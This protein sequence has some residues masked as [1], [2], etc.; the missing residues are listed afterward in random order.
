[1]DENETNDRQDPAEVKSTETEV[2]TE[3]DPQGAVAANLA[4]NPNPSP[5][6]PTES[7]PVDS[8]LQESPGPDSAQQEATP[9]EPQQSNSDEG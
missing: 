5:A 3:H 2:Q 4:K 1:M 8:P 9:E 6:V 7:A